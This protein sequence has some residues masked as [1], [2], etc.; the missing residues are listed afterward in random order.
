LKTIR[1]AS[2]NANLAQKIRDPWN[3]QTHLHRAPGGRSAAST[4]S[5][6]G[7]LEEAVE[8]AA[9]QPLAQVGTIEVR[10]LWG[11]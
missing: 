8:I 6:A 9:T 10:P 3:G 11:N 7:S 4:C 5:S 2:W 1:F